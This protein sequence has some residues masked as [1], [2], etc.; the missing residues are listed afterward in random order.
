MT[1]QPDD[2]FEGTPGLAADLTR[3]LA[4]EATAAV[5]DVT[6]N[7]RTTLGVANAA[8]DRDEQTWHQAWAA[9]AADTLAQL[10]PYLPPAAT[11]ALR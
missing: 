7:I 1:Q 11:A 2:P 4:D 3:V 10:A 5:A 9:G 6:D 8:A